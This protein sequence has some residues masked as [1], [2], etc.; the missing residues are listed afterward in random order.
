MKRQELLLGRPAPPLL[1]F[2]ID[3]A[4]INRLMGEEG[5][6]ASSAGKT[7]PFGR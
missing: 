5:I 7:H 6:A 1:F 3:E 4:V 2:I